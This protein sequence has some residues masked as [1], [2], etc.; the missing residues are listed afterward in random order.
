MSHPEKVDD[1]M[2]MDEILAS[3][4][5]IISAETKVE[6]KKEVNTF[7]Q[8]EGYDTIPF[9]TPL[10]AAPQ[11]TVPEHEGK[12]SVESEQEPVKPFLSGTKKTLY[13]FTKEGTGE[14]SSNPP[15]F[16]NVTSLP[17]ASGIPIRN[18]TPVIPE[19]VISE[20]SSP[21][22]EQEATKETTYGFTK[23]E[24]GEFSAA[25]SVFENITPLPIAPSISVQNVTRINPQTVVLEN[26]SPVAEK[27]TLYGV[28]KEGTGEFSA[29]PPVFGN[30]KSISPAPSISTQ[31]VTR[32][33]SQTV[34]SENPELIAK[35]VIVKEGIEEFCAAPSVFGNVTSLLT[36]PN[37]SMRDATRVH[38]QTAPITETGTTKETLYGFTKEGARVFSAVPPVFGNI[39]SIS[40]VS[41]ISTQNTTHISPQTAVLEKETPKEETGESLTT[42]S[43]LKNLTSLLNASSISLHN[44]AQVIPENSPL[45]GEKE[46][47]ETIIPT[48]SIPSLDMGNQN[49]QLQAFIYDLIQPLLKDWVNAY[50]P[51]LVEKTV[52]QEVTKMFQKLREP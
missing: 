51:S 47:P 40:A 52:A 26:A 4:R 17:T 3:I 20:N 34:V 14:F 31:N 8:K 30:V 16:G 12:P 33:S 38:S 27:E 2:S 48:P 1:D 32:M 28:T 49:S 35:K 36:V 21:V 5:R 46:T 22:A 18:I 23:E 39:M 42:P 6:E 29:A 10:P 9:P 15:V 19:T 44:I 50:L 7:S 24:A 41:N 13:G 25:P 45:T 37:I 43:S 11:S